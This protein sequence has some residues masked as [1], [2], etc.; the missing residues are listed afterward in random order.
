MRGAT[1]R[2]VAEIA[3]AMHDL[4]AA[5]EEHLT[6][7]LLAGLAGEITALPVRTRLVGGAGPHLRVGHR[8]VTKKEERANGADIGVVVDVRLPGR[9]HT[10][11]RETLIQVK[12]SAV[13]TPGCAG[14]EDSWTD[15]RHQL[16]DLENRSSSVY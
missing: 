8:T 16:H 3:D 9:L 4:G 2:A 7:T 5:E 15:K 11:A 13:L 14:R 6:A 1:R 10:C 12:K